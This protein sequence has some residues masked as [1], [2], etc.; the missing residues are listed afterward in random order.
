MTT[1]PAPAHGLDHP[2]YDD[3]LHYLA[4][5]EDPHGRISP[6]VVAAMTFPHVTFRLVGKA[7]FDEGRDRVSE[8]PWQLEP[9]EVLATD[10][11]FVAVVG[12]TAVT[13]DGATM[14]THT[15]TLVTLTD[16]IVTSLQHWC[17]GAL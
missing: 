1:T 8:H 3:F 10:A 16:G 6:D 12:A 2:A 5:G 7:A 17:S 15:I 13:R 14:R 11:G 9:H 4:T